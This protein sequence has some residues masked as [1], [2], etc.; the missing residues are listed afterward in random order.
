MRTL[1]RF[2]R[3]CRNRGPDLAE[4]LYA[5]E[6][7]GRKPVKTCPECGRHWKLRIDW[8][9]LAQ[10][11]P[12]HSD[13][14]LSPEAEALEDHLRDEALRQREV[15]GEEGRGETDERCT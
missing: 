13:D 3:T 14:P 11:V 10:S 12:S 9:L 5:A 1:G 6:R 8:Q 7:A 15:Q 4:E 2:C